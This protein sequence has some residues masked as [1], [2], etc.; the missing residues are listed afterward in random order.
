M[1]AEYQMMPEK[2]SV[3]HEHYSYLLNIP[4]KGRSRAALYTGG[5]GFGQG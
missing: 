5:K 4:A 1:V 3:R 2:V